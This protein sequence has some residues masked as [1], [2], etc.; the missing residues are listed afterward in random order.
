MR[1][2]YLS[3]FYPLRGGIAQFNADLLEALGRENRVK[4]YTF[5]RQY[6][7]FLFPGTSQYVT[8][9]DKARPVDS[10]AVLDTMNP[11]SY[12]S[13]ARKIA[14]WH[15]DLVLMK[16][17]MSYLA[18][19]LGSVAGLL[20][21]KGIKVVTILDNVMPHERKFFDKPFT[22][23]FIERN[24]GCIAMSPTVLE[25]MLSLVPSKPHI[26]IDHPLYNHFGA[27]T[28]RGEACRRLGIDPSCKVL[29]FFGL[30]RE[31]KGLDI[32][33]EA[34]RGLDS[35]YQLLIAG[36]CYGDFAP[37]RKQ[38]ET[39]DSERVKVFNRYIPDEEVPLFFSASDLCV[40]PYRS[41]TQSGI[42]AISTH[43]DL[44]VVA[45]PVGALPHTVAESGIGLIASEASPEAIRATVER[46]FN[47]DRGKYIEAIA[48][49]K[50]EST[51]ERF[52]Q[53][54]IK[55]SETI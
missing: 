32:L 42:T 34:F 16:Y 36:E 11:L 37:Y 18:P 41:A 6:P 7:G 45:T 39:L 10:E 9:Q 1:I 27:K 35:S 54:T 14:S 20:R 2:A 24:S 52:A 30:I 28:D 19:S 4:A 53:K 22:K 43:F 40:L 46:F 17:W 44:P 55:F 26:L 51:W 21:R 47:D 48:R 33:I 13:A 3:T 50:A 23:W 31:Y 29:L 12:I 38:L 15:P 25:D 5:S 49:I 8:P